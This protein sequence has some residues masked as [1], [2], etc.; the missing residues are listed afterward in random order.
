MLASFF[1]CVCY[2]QELADVA[3]HVATFIIGMSSGT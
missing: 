3:K 2:D 1:F